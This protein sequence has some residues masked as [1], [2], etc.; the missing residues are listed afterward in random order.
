MKVTIKQSDSES[1]VGTVGPPHWRT[2]LNNWTLV[3]VFRMAIFVLYCGMILWTAGCKG[4]GL[5]VKSTVPYKR[6]D[7][8]LRLLRYNAVQ[9]A[10]SQPTFRGNMSPPSSGPKN[11][12]SEK[13]AEPASCFMLVSGL[14]Y[15]S[16]L[17]MRKACTSKTSVDF[18]RITTRRYIP[19]DGTLH[20]HRCENLKYIYILRYITSVI[21]VYE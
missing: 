8:H 14:V 15:S 2:H 19:E 11:K 7:S 13:P 18:Q 12:S 4:L 16:T 6:N 1:R 10:E 20:N 17:K 21:I 5:L 3:R 9:S